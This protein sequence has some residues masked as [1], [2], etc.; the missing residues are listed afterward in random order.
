M[1]IILSYFC[2]WVCN[3]E[4]CTVIY[5]S[6]FR[7]HMEKSVSW[8]YEMWPLRTVDYTPVS[9][10]TQ[11]GSYPW[12]PDLLSMTRTYPAIPQTG[13]QHNTST[14]YICWSNNLWSSR[15]NEEEL[16][17]HSKYEWLQI[18]D[19][20]LTTEFQNCATDC[21]GKTRTKKVFNEYKFSCSFPT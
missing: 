21:C 8:K 19:S 5:L 18:N 3:T 14:S 10:P 11:Q 16:I 6:S 1:F 4:C 7:S 9:W 2:I 12:I 20:L 17:R 15:S 13:Y